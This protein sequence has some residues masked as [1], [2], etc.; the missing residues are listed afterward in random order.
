[1]ALFSVLY[2]EAGIPSDR[3][4]Y[5]PEF[6]AMASR[7]GVTEEELWEHILDARGRNHGKT[8]E[9]LPDIE[10]KS[11][12]KRRPP[13]DPN[14]CE[15]FEQTLEPHVIANAENFIYTFAF[16]L[17]C[18]GRLDR[19]RNEWAYDMIR[20]RKFKATHVPGAMPGD[21]NSTLAAPTEF[22]VATHADAGFSFIG[23]APHPTAF[24]KV[25]TITR[26]ECVRLRSMYADAFISCSTYRVSDDA[27]RAA[28]DDEDV[29]I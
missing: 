11:R 22:V 3:L 15:L 24:A 16:R 21:D 25:K 17:W 29:V 10:G 7:V 14:H 13:L 6:E 8:N 23:P 18:S 20:Y 19:S 9:E 26:D 27:M 28:C 12:A 1:M 4:P 2:A 5:S